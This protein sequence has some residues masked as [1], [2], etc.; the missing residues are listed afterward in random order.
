MSE[1]IRHRKTASILPRAD[2]FSR[3]SLPFQIKTDGNR[4]I[5]LPGSRESPIKNRGI[6]KI[7]ERGNEKGGKG[8]G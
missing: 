4:L 8:R 1:R 5:I 7:G 6:K 3:S 2:K